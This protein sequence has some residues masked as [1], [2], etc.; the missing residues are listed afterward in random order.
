LRGAKEAAGRMVAEKL[1][2]ADLAAVAVLS[3]KHGLKA[4]V[5][6]T[7]DREQLGRAVRSLGRAEEPDPSDPLGLTFMR[8]AGKPTTAFYDEADNDDR[9][10]DAATSPPELHEF[11]V[12]RFLSNLKSVADALREIQGPKQVV[13]F[14]AG[15]KERTLVGLRSESGSYAER[16]MP[17]NASGGGYRSAGTHGGGLARTE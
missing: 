12:M 10:E 7:S 15:F 2:P 11:H 5:G 8:S 3:T 1:G 17:P 4:L 9:G 16:N 14:S 6:F 13:L